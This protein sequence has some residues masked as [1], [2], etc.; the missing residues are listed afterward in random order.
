[1]AELRLEKA[2]SP[3]E[4]SSAAFNSYLLLQVLSND[5]IRV[6]LPSAI[7]TLR[8]SGPSS[9]SLSL[10][11]RVMEG[12]GL[13]LAVVATFKEVYLLSKFIQQTVLSIKNKM[14]SALS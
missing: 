4:T 5:G 12:V 8:E 7:K 9:V 10:H 3:P 13:A 11:T 6:R 1:V 14:P 2:C